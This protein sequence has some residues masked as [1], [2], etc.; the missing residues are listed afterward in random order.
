MP[1][2]LT[3]SDFFLCGSLS[4]ADPHVRTRKSQAL[5]VGLASSHFAV[6]VDGGDGV[7]GLAVAHQMDVV[8]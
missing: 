2:L 3:L 4:A 7:F 1:C 6:V 8:V 5:L